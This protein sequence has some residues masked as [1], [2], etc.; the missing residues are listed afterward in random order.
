MPN[1]KF[2]D[3]KMNDVD[4]KT[5]V[6]GFIAVA[7]PGES[8]KEEIEEYYQKV[9]RKASQCRMI[10]FKL[11]QLTNNWGDPSLNDTRG[12][13]SA[14]MSKYNSKEEALQ[15]LEKNEKELNEWMEL[16]EQ[17]DEI[18]NQNK[19][20]NKTLCFSNI[21]ELIKENPD[22]KIGQIEKEAGIRLG[23]MSRLEKGD[24]T[25]EP[26]VEFIVTAAKLLNVSVDTL[27]SI[28]LASLTPTEKY[29]VSFI[30][31][32]KS[33]TLLD[34]L[35]WSIET[36]FELDRWEVDYNGNSIHP[37]F[38]LETYYRQTDCE[39]PEEA[40]ENVYVSKTFGPNTSIN[41]DCF[42]LRLKNGSTF[43]LM[44][45]VKD[46]H[47]VND[48]SA[49]VKEAVMYVPRG[50]TQVLAT[51]QDEYPIGSLLEELHSTLK[52]RM[53]H[54]QVNNDVMYAIDAFMKDDLK[55]DE[56]ELPF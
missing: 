36:K 7:K 45:I 26:S 40:T 51:T 28:D 56:E 33:D 25:S 20:F 24:N 8:T 14:I 18:R 53:K 55:D 11:K 2:L 29:L 35:N 54:P 49:F 5:K 12:V 19:N 38:S 30:E 34:K 17:L 13:I 4:F 15:D 31:K 16:C 3:T 6:K 50:K 42:S 46:V 47:R 9:T 41:G 43:Y 37:L 10:T 39:Y 23:Y 32:L 1:D 52:E 48:K 27:I 21:R 44:D 22:V